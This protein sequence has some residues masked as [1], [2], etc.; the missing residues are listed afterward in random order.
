MWVELWSFNS[1]VN[2]NRSSR[3]CSLFIKVPADLCAFIECNFKSN[4]KQ[5]AQTTCRDFRAILFPFALG[6]PFLKDS[7]F[8][9]FWKSE[10]NNLQSFTTA[11]K[12]VLFHIFFFGNS[13]EFLNPPLKNHNFSEP[14]LKILWFSEPPFKKSQL[15]LSPL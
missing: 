14:L 12:G 9:I 8:C 2:A 13:I 10:K 5:M 15:F 6:Q 4:R 11:L 7:S 3:S 1:R